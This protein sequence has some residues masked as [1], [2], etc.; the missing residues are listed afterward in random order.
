MCSISN[1]DLVTKFLEDAENFF[2]APRP[3]R[4]TFDVQEIPNALHAD[5]DAARNHVTIRIQPGWDDYQRRGR[6]AHESFHVF[7]PATLAE[8]T[9]LDEGLA[10]L[11][12]KQCLSYLPPPDQKKYCEALSL[13]ERLIAACPGAIKKLT[14]GGKRIALASANDIVSVCKDFPAGDADLLVRKFYA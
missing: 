12:A 11:L 8:A 13:T 10:T 3:V 4:A 9:Y 2:C 14:R 6:L 1:Q 7:S 5:W